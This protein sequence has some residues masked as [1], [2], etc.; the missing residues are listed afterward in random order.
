M[1]LFNN[2]MEKKAGPDPLVIMPQSVPVQ[3]VP[4]PQPTRS[5]ASRATMPQQNTHAQTVGARAYIDQ[6]SKISGKLE[7]A[8][9]AQ[10][11]GQVD[12]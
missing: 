3:A 6:G 12:G 7:F 5:D 2:E 9:P 4:L 8:G 11:E 10:I 1:G